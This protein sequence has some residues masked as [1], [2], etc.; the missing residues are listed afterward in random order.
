MSVRACTT[1]VTIVV[2]ARVTVA[3]SVKKK[4]KKVGFMLIMGIIS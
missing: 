4:L 2:A 1:P 3:Q